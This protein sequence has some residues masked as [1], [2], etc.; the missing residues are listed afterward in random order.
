MNGEDLIEWKL[1]SFLCKP[2]V[3]LHTHT[4]TYCSLPL[5]GL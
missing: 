4:H 1:E 5:T 2:C 3:Y